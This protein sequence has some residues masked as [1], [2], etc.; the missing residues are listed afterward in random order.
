[1]KKI[2]TF[3]FALFIPYLCMGAGVKLTVDLTAEKHLAAFLEE[4]RTTDVP[5]FSYTG[6]AEL[7]LKGDVVTADYA[8]MKAM[9][10]I[11]VLDFTQT[12]ITSV[13]TFAFSES[14]G[15]DV[16][17]I[18][19]LQEVKLPQ[20]LVSIESYAF[21]GCSNLKAI[22]LDACDNLTTLA[23]SSLYGT[24]ITDFRI[25]KGVSK[26]DGTAL[27]NNLKAVSITVNSENKNYEAYQNA[28][29]SKAT[30][31]LIYYPFACPQK[32]LEVK[33]GT[34]KIGWEV[35]RLQTHIEEVVFPAGL[36]TIDI[37]AFP[38]CKNLKK[39]NL[40]EGLK[41]LGE[42]AF[43]QT[44]LE[45]IEIPASI[46]TI[47][48]GVFQ[49]CVNLKKVVVNGAVTTI[50]MNAFAECSLLETVD[51]SDLS[52]LSKTDMQVF[53]ACENL[54]VVDWSKAV[55]LT[56]I[57][58]KTFAGCT[59]LTNVIL[60]NT[61]QKLEVSAFDGCESLNLTSFPTALTSIGNY[62][63]R[64]NKSLT[65]IEIGANLE[66]IGTG[67]FSNCTGVTDLIV[68]DNNFF[69]KSDEGFLTN[70]DADRI[71]F[72][73]ANANITEFTLP[74]GI[75]VIDDYAFVGNKNLVSFSATADLTSIGAGAFADCAKLKTINLARASKLTTIG[76]DAFAACTAL[77]AV[78]WMGDKDQATLVLNQG[79]F[80]YCTALESVQ[81]PKQTKT[82][83][84]SLFEGCTALASADLSKVVNVSNL[85]NMFVGCRALASVQLPQNGV[86]TALGANVFKG[87]AS[88][89][90]I[91]LPASLKKAGGFVGQMMEES[92]I[93]AIAVAANHPA[94]K[95]IDGVLYSADS[96]TLYAYPTAKKGDCIIPDGVEVIYGKAFCGVSDITR[97]TLPASL[98]PYAYNCVKGAFLNMLNLREFILKDGSMN[99]AVENGVLYS[100][101]FKTLYFYPAAKADVFALNPAVENLESNAFQYNP[102]L[103]DVVV[104]APLLKF[105]NYAF[106]DLPNL[107]SLDLP[108]TVVNMGYAVKDCPQ[109]KRVVVRATALPVATKST[110]V[111]CHE[112]LEV[113]V[114]EAAFNKYK[115]DKYW[116]SFNLVPFNET[117][118]DQIE[119]SAATDV[120]FSFYNGILS[121]LSAEKIAWTEV[122]NLH[123]A[124][125]IKSA[126]MEIDLS[127]VIAQ[128]A[129]IVV[130]LE[131]GKSIMRKV[132]IQ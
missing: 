55:K 22:N 102:H 132:M 27:G 110:F 70:I 125:L 51:F 9:A 19:S 100:K 44:G 112:S 57:E 127:H 81:L 60:P 28:L 118:I 105:L 103:T 98:K 50:D 82:T 107:T 5:G 95:V 71:I 89:K 69:M 34:K 46:T 49:R 122:Y 92:G 62:A 85:G 93:E 77:T 88:L 76:Q 78:T 54:K 104:E 121:L 17:G 32:K 12:S 15:L 16:V 114:P 52:Q 64:N 120:K 26:I 117:G 48:P 124:L 75:G 126:D 91:T 63:F 1:M 58:N 65:R 115:Q 37:N 131:N 53:M 41:T 123:G 20:T 74:E 24:A 129:I 38:E 36:E 116:G 56:S 73:P 68:D 23:A 30:A 113:H 29:Y 97:I 31:E 83:A 39:V 4:Y 109:L 94:Y 35:F 130:R 42:G 119:E 84:N 8:T 66:T 111:N 25:G 106:M 80:R 99:Y 101:D 3:F 18:E 40:P 10:G 47:D 87:C 43:G 79:A 6:V 67:A 13:P 14:T 11:E 7:I 90:T 86:L 59:S 61:I 2:S 108:A 72:V 45:S 33:S 128:P 21:C 96:K